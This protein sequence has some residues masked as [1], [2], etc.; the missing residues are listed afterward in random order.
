MRSRL[1]DTPKRVG[2]A[3]RRW[4]PKNTCTLLEPAAG[5]GAL[6]SAVASRLTFA[7]QILAVDRDHRAITG[8]DR[9]TRKAFGKRLKLVRADF[10]KWKPD[11]RQGHPELFDCVLMNP[12]Y[13]AR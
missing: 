8:F 3:L 5:I 4:I 1:Y 13:M 11:S 9:G 6:V 7:T 10:L 2:S 12:P